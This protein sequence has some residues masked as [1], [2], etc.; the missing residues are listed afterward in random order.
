MDDDVAPD[1]AR[2]LIESMARSFRIL[3]EPVAAFAEMHERPHREA[4]QRTANLQL[5][6]DVLARAGFGGLEPGR[7]QTRDGILAE[8]KPLP[9]PAQ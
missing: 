9:L 8:W 2:G 5:A 7:P 6:R 3:R 1:A 4:A